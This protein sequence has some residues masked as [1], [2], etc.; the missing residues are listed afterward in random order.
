MSEDISFNFVIANIQTS[1]MLHWSLKQFST[2]FT[3]PVKQAF[4]QCCYL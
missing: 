4:I 2:V 3:D 1:V